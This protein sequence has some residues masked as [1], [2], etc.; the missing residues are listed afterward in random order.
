MSVPTMSSTAL[1]TEHLE[2]PPVSLVDDLINSVNEIMYKCTQAMETY[3]QQRSVIGGRDYTEEIRVGTAKLET[4]LEN[5]V[6]K[7]LDRLELYVL[8]N[9]LSL[10]SELIENGS[11]R[12][13]H[14]EGLVLH[15]DM[16]TEME[17]RFVAVEKAFQVHEMLRARLGETRRVYERTVKFK[18]LVLRLLEGGLKGKEDKDNNRNL[19]VLLNSLKP[20]DETMRLLASQLRALYVENEKF[21]SS[22]SIEL[23]LEK[24]SGLQDSG[25]TRSGY[26]DNRTRRLFENL[27]QEEADEEGRAIPL[28]GSPTEEDQSTIS[29]VDDINH[30]DWS[31]IQKYT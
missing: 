4:L 6:D 26:I 27:F 13:G 16:G 29:Q 19:E 12:L 30:P 7:N 14:Y 25:A 5:A 9:V 3:L 20:V 18:R 10:P 23:L 17:E 2:F 1:L 31:A 28:G 24:Y 21:C 8:R 22:T 15:E 11:F